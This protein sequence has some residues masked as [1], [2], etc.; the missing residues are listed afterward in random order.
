MW[1]SFAQFA[2]PPAQ[3]LPHLRVERAERLIQQ[4]HLRLHGERAGQRDALAL[5]TGKL[6][7]K[8]LGE[9]FELDEFQQVTDACLN[10]FFGWA[11]R[12]RANAQAERNVFE[13]GHVPEQRVMLE[14]KA[15]L[16]LARGNLRHVLA[17]KQGPRRAGIVGNSRRRWCGAAWFCRSRTVRAARRVRRTRP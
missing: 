11:R 8:P 10:F 17:V 5:A 15:G 14:G 7:R 16:A 3:L 12:F 2:Q 6:G 4:Q 1:I 13:H 9:R